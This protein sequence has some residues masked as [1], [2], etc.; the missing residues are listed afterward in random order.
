LLISRGLLP[1]MAAPRQD[2]TPVTL[3][4]KISS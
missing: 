4:V 2:I 3:K 1:V